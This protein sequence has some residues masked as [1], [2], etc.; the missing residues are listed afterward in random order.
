MGKIKKIDKLTSKQKIIIPTED[1]ED[2]SI[3]YEMPQFYPKDPNHPGLSDMISIFTIR[4]T[5]KKMDGDKIQKILGVI[6]I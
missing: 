1:I 5:T 4:I 2:I 6:K 3:S